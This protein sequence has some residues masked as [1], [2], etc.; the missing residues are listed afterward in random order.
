MRAF[1]WT[2]FSQYQTAISNNPPE[3]LG[4]QKAC[5]PLGTCPVYPVFSAALL[6]PKEYMKT[7][8][9]TGKSDSF[10]KI[11]NVRVT[12]EKCLLQMQQTNNREA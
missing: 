9:Q 10:R 12:H 1:S 5:G 6:S 3:S 8:N 2:L 11:N 4:P 7:F